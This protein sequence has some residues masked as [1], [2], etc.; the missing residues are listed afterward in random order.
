MRRPR[1]AES[2]GRNRRN[3]RSESDLIE[4][5]LYR[6]DASERRRLDDDGRRRPE[7]RSQE[8]K[9][10]ASQAAAFR[11]PDEAANNAKKGEG[12]PHPL[13]WPQPLV[14]DQEGGAKRDQKRRR[15]EKHR[16]SRGGGEAQRFVKRDEF[17]GEQGAGERACGLRAVNLEDAAL[18][19]ERIGN[20]AQ[21]AD[22]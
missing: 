3:E 2:I 21:R 15:V 6:I 18:R 20:H 22:A 16:R 13:D 12:E 11:S 10:V 4:K 8:R 14:L 19:G 17:G 9:R 1:F 5:D 7:R